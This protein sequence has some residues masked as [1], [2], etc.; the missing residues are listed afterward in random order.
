MSGL[1]SAEGGHDGQWLEKGGVMEG[2][3]P[4]R[5]WLK[6]ERETRL[7][8][9]QKKLGEKI[10]CSERH[11]RRVEKGERPMRR[12]DAEPLADLLE[13]TPEQRGT[14]IRWALG[15]P[16]LEPHNP[17][18]PGT[19]LQPGT[20]IV[21][22]TEA[23]DYIIVAVGPGGPDVSCRGEACNGQ[24]PGTT[25]CAKGATTAAT[26]EIRDGQNRVVGWVDL[27]WSELCAT[28]WARV[29]NTSGQPHLLMRTYLRDTTGS[30]IEET[31]VEARGQGF[32]GK[33]WY[34]P[35]GEVVVQACA[36]I[37]GCAEVC[38]NPI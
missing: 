38:T 1:V 12:Q 34:A 11:I 7:A 19:V 37:E 25:G 10:G 27:R 23:E 5:V 13:V 36:I 16:P 6:Q 31:V 32:Y 33:M 2:D 26:A 9:T 17:L 28:N 4:F 24:D 29:E 22:P 8:L 30:V 14:F 20:A 21:R 3:T 18:P 35:T 15:L